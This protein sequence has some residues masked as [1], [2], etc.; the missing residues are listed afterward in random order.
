MNQ[1]LNIRIDNKEV[2]RLAKEKYE[3]HLKRV[4]KEQVY[5]ELHRI[6]CS[7]TGLKLMGRGI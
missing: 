1:P 2:E 7:I 5:K 4:N 6:D 3:A